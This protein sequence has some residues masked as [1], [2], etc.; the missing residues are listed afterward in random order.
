MTRLIRSASFNPQAPGRMRRVPGLAE[1]FIPVQKMMETKQ[2][3]APCGLQADS[4]AR[5]I[6]KGSFNPQVLR[7]TLR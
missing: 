7:Q 1:K 2:S 5:L 3:E 6:R 4:A